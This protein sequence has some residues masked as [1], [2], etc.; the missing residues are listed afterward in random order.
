MVM[1]Y[2]DGGSLQSLIAGVDLNEGQIANVL[3]KVLC[4]LDYL[5]KQN[6]IHRDIKVAHPPTRPTTHL[7]ISSAVYFSAATWCRPT[8]FSSTSTER[9]KSVR[10]LPPLSFLSFRSLS[11]AL[12]LH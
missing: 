8:T 10:A 2:C 12:L 6:R 7:C 1:E 4:G 5:H 3:R 11:F 9:S